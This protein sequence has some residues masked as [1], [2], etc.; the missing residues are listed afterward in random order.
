[1]LLQF[2]EPLSD[3]ATI[4]ETEIA[5][6]LQ[7]K[8]ICVICFPNYPSKETG[9]GI[10][11]YSYE[12]LKGLKQQGL[13]PMTLEDGAVKS[14]LQY[15]VK[16]TRVFAKVI[17]IEADLYH[18]VSELAAKNMILAKKSLSITTVH[19]VL[20]LYFYPTAPT[21][22][23]YQKSCLKLATRS[24]RLIATSETTRNLLTNLLKV[25]AE[26]VSVVYYGINHQMFKPTPKIEKENKTILYVG[27]LA[28]LKG[29]HV[30]IEAFKLV[31]K[32][33]KNVELKIGGK[34]KDHALI[35]EV[36]HQPN[37]KSHIKLLGFIK[38]E[39]LSEYYRSSDVFV[40]PAYS[41]ISLSVLDAM[42][43]GTPVVVNNAFDAPEYIG[44][45][46]ILVEPGDVHK[47]AEA[48][49]YVL[50]N[51]DVERVYSQR[52]IKRAEFFTWEK[53]VKET[54]NLYN[55]ALNKY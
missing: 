54:W 22:Y 11:K 52:A 38:D 27:S 14:P 41:G 16:D 33:L 42:A 37:I 53:M 24:N 35:Q 49:M 30:L 36:L 4:V 29:I 1:M 39:E 50:G 10:D 43:C 55:E 44:E 45:A 21:K 19:D 12:L 15:M 23:W 32:E 20:A 13:S 34:C 46:G 18:A 8:K 25:P 26:K 17:R 28:R 6:N 31:Q 7:G 48:L 2:Q 5:S 9:R 47:L 40:W 3:E 51:E